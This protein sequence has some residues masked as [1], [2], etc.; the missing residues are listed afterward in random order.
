MAKFSRDK[1]SREERSLIADLKEVGYLDARRVPLSGAM[2]GF[3]FDVLGTSPAGVPHSFEMKSRRD[4]FSSIY[5]LLN[6][7]RGEDSCV[8]FTVN[9]PDFPYFVI[10][11]TKLI[12]LTTTGNYALIQKDNK[13]YRTFKRIAN[14]DKLRAGATFLCIKNNNKPRIFLRYW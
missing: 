6:K 2:R 7:Y 12:D 13:D 9:S 8:R 10:F 11:G 3:K 14:L 5:A 4:A 1:G